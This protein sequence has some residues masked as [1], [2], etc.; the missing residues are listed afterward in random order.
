M[1]SSSTLSIRRVT[2]TA[3]STSAGVG[4]PK[5]VPFSAAEATASSTAGWACPWIKGPQEQT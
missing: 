4:A 3:S 5:L 2:S 1:R